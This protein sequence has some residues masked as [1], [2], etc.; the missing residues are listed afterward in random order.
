METLS[1]PSLQLGRL[2]YPYS[3]SY[4]FISEYQ[5]THGIS[6]VRVLKMPFR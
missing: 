1:I 6:D 5:I 2:N 3:E 4:V